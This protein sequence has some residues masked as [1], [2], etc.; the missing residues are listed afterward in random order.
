[1][2]TVGVTVLG[3]V[4]G[5]AAPAAPASAVP[6]EPGPSG[7]IQVT[8]RQT[9]P[10]SQVAL[11]TEHCDVERT[12]FATSVAFEADVDLERTGN[13]S[14]FRGYAMI[15]VDAEAGTYGLTV[16][17][18]EHEK[19]QQGSFR[20]VSASTGGHEDGGW[21][22]GRDGGWDGGWDGGGRDHESPHD[23]HASPVA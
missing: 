10:G 7:P 23:P 22:G 4:C 14:A 19:E 2:V 13:G 9:E 17:C 18:G 16:V 5:F 1:M 15:S 8:P 12:A 3:A 21:D 20:V 11:R 6:A